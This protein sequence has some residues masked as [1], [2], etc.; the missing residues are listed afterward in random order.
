VH[1]CWVGRPTQDLVRG[2]RGGDERGIRS[3]ASDALVTKLMG[4]G[5]DELTV[6]DLV[7]DLEDV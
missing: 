6:D 3:K 7:G 1:A 4:E 5:A 2:K